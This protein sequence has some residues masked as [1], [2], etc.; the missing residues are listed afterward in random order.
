MI[1]AVVL[2]FGIAF[3]AGL[4][5]VTPI[6]AV[7]FP[8]GGW[9]MA[10]SL[11]AALG[12]IVADKLPRTGSRLAPIPL[13]ARCAAG[14][15]VAVVVGGKLGLDITPAALIGILGAVCG[16]FAGAGYRKWVAALHLPDLWFALV[17]DAVA[18]AIAFWIALSVV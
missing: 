14:G 15:A 9:P 13:V 4:R 12:E 8:R 3:T 7:L 16:A 1:S 6:A 11:L 2:A 5:V 10:V 18:V 17:E